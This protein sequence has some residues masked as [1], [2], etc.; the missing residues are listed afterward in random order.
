MSDVL[1]SPGIGGQSSSIILDIGTQ[2]IRVGYGG[3]DL[4]K[5]IVP[6]CIGVPNQDV[7]VLDPNRFGNTVFPLKPWEKRDHIEVFYPFQYNNQQKTI[8]IHDEYLIKMIQEISLPQKFTNCNSA[9]STRHNYI[10]EPLDEKISGHSLVIPIHPISNPNHSEKISEIAF[11]K[12]EVSSLFTSRR[13]VLSC[14]SCG[15]TS[16]IVVDIGAS[17]SNVSCIQDGHCIQKSIQDYPVAG[18]FLDNEIY[19]KIHSKTN[20][21]P[22]FGVFKSGD[23]TGASSYCVP[24]TNVDTSYLNWGIMH[25]IREIKHACLYFPNTSTPTNEGSEF[26]LPDGSVIDTTP[27]RNSIPN[28]LFKSINSSQ[29]Y[30][31]II[32][33]IVNSVN[34]TLSINKEI[35]NITS[36]IILSGGT[37]LISGFESKL[38]QGIVDQKSSAI[39]SN[40]PFPV[41]RI[42]ASPRAPERLASAWIGASILSSLGTFHQ[43]TVSKRVS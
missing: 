1:L 41:P 15:R 16:G 2:S 3:D 28:L 43:F 18:D 39:S 12:L 34:E 26:Q 29:G 11:E 22:E 4:P 31:G 36:S 33:M 9:Y 25:I 17:A 21:I 13:P 8:D 27:I 30:P 5:S 35:S 38:H 24:L 7:D 20:I 42:V 40:S 23:R 32:Q 10:F 6:T 14:F 19:K 37:T